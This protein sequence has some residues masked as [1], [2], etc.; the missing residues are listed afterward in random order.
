MAVCGTLLCNA[1][2]GERIKILRYSASMRVR[3]VRMMLYNAGAAHP[4][5]MIR[6]EF[7]K[8]NHIRYNEA[9]HRAQDYALWSEI[10]YRGGE[11]AYS[12]ESDAEIPDA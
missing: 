7:L 2:N 5:S 1:E 11:D 12:A 9:F 8:K 6:T 4:S 10:I 3:A